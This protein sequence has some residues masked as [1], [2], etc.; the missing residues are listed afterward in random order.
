M[1]TDLEKLLLSAILCLVIALTATLYG[2]NVSVREM[3]QAMKPLRETVAK[4][5]E[6]LP[7]NRQ[8]RLIYSAEVVK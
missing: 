5:E 8:C 4:C 7:R 2:W 3:N 6:N 1:T